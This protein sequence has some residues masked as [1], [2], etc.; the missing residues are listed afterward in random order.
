MVFACDFAGD[1]THIGERQIPARTGLLSI[2]VPGRSAVGSDAPVAGGSLQ[3]FES[4]SQSAAELIATER[5]QL[6]LRVV[7][8]I[9]VDRLESE[10]FQTTRQLV[11]QVS[12]R[13]AVA[14]A[15]DL[16]RTCEAFLDN[17]LHNP[18]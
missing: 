8:V 13:H 14:A 6:T 15:D 5:F 4:G 11:F 7:N 10:V 9:D 12:G 18:R 16:I 3:E 1:R 17:V 2:T